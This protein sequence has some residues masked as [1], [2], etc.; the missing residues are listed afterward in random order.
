MLKRLLRSTVR[1]YVKKRREGIIHF[2]AIA[3]SLP[4]PSPQELERHYDLLCRPILENLQEVLKEEGLTDD[5]DTAAK[6]MIHFARN[7]LESKDV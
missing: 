7:M 1:G 2:I 5:P 4:A 6:L 3:G